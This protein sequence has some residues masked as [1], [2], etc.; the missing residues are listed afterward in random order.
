[1]IGNIIFPSSDCGRI[2]TILFKFIVLDQDGLIDE[3]F[4]IPLEITE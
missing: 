2:G 3:E 1:M 4:D